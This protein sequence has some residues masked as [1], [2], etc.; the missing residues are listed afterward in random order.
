MYTLRFI[1]LLHFF[2][3]FSVKAQVT[4]AFS[5]LLSEP[6][7]VA[8]EADSSYYDIYRI[9]SS[10]IWFGGESGVLKRMDGNGKITSI[11]YPNKGVNL[12]K[13]IRIKNF[14]YIAADEGIIYR[15]DLS[16][17]SWKV[18][19]F[20]EFRNQCFYDICEGA[21]DRV[22]VCGGATR[23]AHGLKVIPNGF[24]ASVDGELTESPVVSW[25]SVRKFPWALLKTPEGTVI[26]SIFNGVSTRLY[27]S[28][29]AVSYSNWQPEHKI[30]GLVHS[31]NSFNGT[32]Y[33]SGCKSIRYKK[34]G[35]WGYLADKRVHREV[36]ASGLICNLV[37]SGNQL[38]GFTQRG[39]LL[40]LLPETAVP[41]YQATNGIAYYE[42]LISGNNSVY[43]V[44]HG[45]EIREIKLVD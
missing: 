44:G 6:F 22:I 18:K 16:D 2:N 9:S 43:L 5:E 20:E 13:V 25:R 1:V 39:L 29:D 31:L 7:D 10:E 40:R 28:S 14:V 3:P 27:T 32:V 34:N 30:P 42:G 41:V 23:I 33:Y 38:Y 26:V 4:R 17:G 45:K 15:H 37:S 8:S 11:S 24:I 36:T 35:T 12:L 19:F 21:N